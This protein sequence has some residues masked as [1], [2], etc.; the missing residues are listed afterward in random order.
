M[1]LSQSARH[2]ILSFFYLGTPVFVLLDYF[3]EINFRVAALGGSASWSSYKWLYLGVCFLIGVIGLKSQLLQ[4]KLSLLE[5]SVNIL[6][7]CLGVFFNI[8]SYVDETLVGADVQFEFGLFEIFNLLL[9][10]GIFLITF[11][12]NPLFIRKN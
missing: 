3:F 7:L 2:K 8:G 10:G 1:N 5:C 12:N 11:Y 9:S 4:A 6:L